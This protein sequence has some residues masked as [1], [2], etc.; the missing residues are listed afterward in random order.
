MPFMMAA[1]GLATKLVS[2]VPI[3]SPR[4]WG[5]TSDWAA[6][7]STTVTGNR[8]LVITAMA[9]ARKVVSMYSQIT[10]PKRRSSLEEP[11]ARALATIT[12]TSTGAMPFNAPTNRLPNSATQPAPGATSA[13]TTPTAR[14]TRIRRIR[15]TLL[16]FAT[17]AFRVFIL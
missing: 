5:T 11:C 4:P 10:V 6:S 9:A 3:T 8:K 12:N 17:A 14:P 7:A 15:L 13:S 16:Y 1:T 2:R